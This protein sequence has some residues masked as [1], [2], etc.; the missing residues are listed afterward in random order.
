MVF[1]CVLITLLVTQH[2]R[3]NKST[4]SVG[5]LDYLMDAL[6]RGYSLL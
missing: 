5:S 6:S 1:D 2:S 3:L 4:V